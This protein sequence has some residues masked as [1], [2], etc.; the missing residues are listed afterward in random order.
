MNTLEE[1]KRRRMIFYWF[2]F[3]FTLCVTN[4]LL[5]EKALVQISHLYFF[6]FFDFV[7]S[8]VNFSDGRKNVFNEGFDGR[9]I[10]WFDTGGINPNGRRNGNV[11]QNERNDRKKARY[12]WKSVVEK[13][14]SKLGT[15]F[16]DAK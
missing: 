10:W 5:L 7:G 8:W 2:K 12:A 4:V 9:R 3:R 6:K 14:G 1:E 15:E 13:K 11:C 16:T